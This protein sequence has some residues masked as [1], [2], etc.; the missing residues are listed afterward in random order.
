MKIDGRW[1]LTATRRQ[2]NLGSLLALTLFT[3]CYV[4]AQATTGIP[5][6]SGDLVMSYTGSSGATIKSKI[7]SDGQ[8]TRID[9][10]DTSNGVSTIQ[11]L[12]THTTYT[13]MHTRKM[14]MK[15]ERAGLLGSIEILNPLN[16]CANEIRTTCTKSGIETVNGRVCS[17]WVYAGDSNIKTLWLDEKFHLPIKTVNDDD[18]T[19]SL[20]KFQEGPQDPKLFTIPQ[21]YHKFD[22]SAAVN[23]FGLGFL[24]YS[25]FLFG[26]LSLVLRGVCV[27]HWIKRRPNTYW[28]WIIIMGGTLGCFAYVAVEIVPDATLLRRSFAF[29]AR[30]KRIRQLTAIVQDNPAP[31]NYE[32]LG[33]LYLDGKKYA[34]A[35]A[36]FDRAI[37]ART[38]HASP[39]YRRALAS[40]ELK[41]YAA[42]EPDLQRAV[43]IEPKH[44]FQRAAGLLA[45]VLFK[46]GKNAEAG[47]LFAEVAQTSTISETLYHYAEYLATQG[48]GAEARAAL[49]RVLD[50]KATLPVFLKRRERPWF[51]KATSLLKTIPQ[52]AS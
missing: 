27:V 48:K 4:S 14:Y 23:E 26:P 15:T 49:Q 47:K 36:A 46:N 33:D 6:F 5:Q 21:D 18:T 51:R 12:S 38:D 28:L 22:A 41:D 44:D 16:P 40:I 52:T 10:P 19:Y 3:T 39:F 37:T 2:Q 13:L 34:E 8:K 29:V 45:Y 9:S 43:A 50:K 25:F 17:K 24:P 35:R 31:G 30:N 11:D 1:N 7:Y 42:A 20:E 32:E